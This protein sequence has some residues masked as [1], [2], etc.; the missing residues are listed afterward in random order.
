MQAEAAWLRW[1][2]AVLIGAALLLFALVLYLA[3]GALFPLIIGVV[4]AQLLHPVVGFVEVRM[5]RRENWPNGARIFSIL[6]IYS[7]FIAAVAGILFAI[8][9]PLFSE[10]TAFIETFPAF[11]E[12]ARTSI[13]SWSREITERIPEELR[14][15]VEEA[16]ASGGTVLAGAAGGFLSRTVSGA[17][18]AVSVV[19]GL[20]IIPFFLFY[21]LKD[22]DSVLG[23]VFSIMPPTTRRQTT[24]VIRLVNNVIAAYVRA[25]LLSALIVGLLV[26]VGL[27]VLDIPFAAI[28]G[29]VAGLFGLIP[30]I[31]PILG[32]VPGVLVTLASS[33][34]QVIWVLLVYAGVQLIEN[35]AIAPRIHGKAVRLHPGFIMAI[36]ILGSEIAGLWGVIVGVPVTAAAR[37]VFMYFYRQW[38][39]SDTPNGPASVLES[40]S[41]GQETGTDDRET[42]PQPP[43]EQ[44]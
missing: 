19:I 36:L 33:P 14:L 29:L 11:Y 44:L 41:V 9:P 10:A 40:E 4:L 25:Q 23:G 16:V 37:D 27:T 30:I 18:N 2:M 26:F 3:R 1:R 8:I 12:N 28:L 20:A 6:L 34:S 7:L 32:A 39:G 17:S 5:P 42:K 43:E 13:E 35:N 21:L 24:D 22:R 38:S 15:Q 31:G